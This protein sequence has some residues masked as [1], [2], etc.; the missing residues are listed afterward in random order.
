MFDTRQYLFVSMQGKSVNNLQKYATRAQSFFQRVWSG[1]LV[2]RHVVS[3]RSRLDY[4]LKQLTK[5]AMIFCDTNT[6]AK[7]F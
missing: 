3:K 1:S 7:S 2:L 6:I 5:K 4:W